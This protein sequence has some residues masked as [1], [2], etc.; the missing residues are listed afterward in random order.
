M[1]K[2]IYLIFLC[3]FISCYP[4]FSQENYELYPTIYF[5][6][7]QGLDYTV[8]YTN[9]NEVITVVVINGIIYKV[10]YDN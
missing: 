10:N 9:D 3:L 1:K 7:L 5:D 4:L 8:I 2:I 6:E